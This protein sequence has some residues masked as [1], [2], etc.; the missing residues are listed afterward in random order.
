MSG[1]DIKREIRE[2]N[3]ICFEL[4][5]VLCESRYHCQES[6]WRYLEKTQGIGQFFYNR[7]Q[8]EKQRTRYRPYDIEE[9]YSSYLVNTFADMSEAK[10][11]CDL[12]EKLFLD[13]IVPRDKMLELLQYAIDEGK[14]IYLVSE[15]PYSK[16]LIHE[17]LEKI[18]IKKEF[19]C[20][21][22]KD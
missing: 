8:A 16:N 13:S 9:I 10:E 6:L 20:Y 21:P 4:M 18:E 11:L 7:S 2:N 19:S 22:G 1:E 15:L 17:L 12:E 3:V 14:R 5:G